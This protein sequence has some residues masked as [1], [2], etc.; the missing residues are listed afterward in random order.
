MIRKHKKNKLK[1]TGNMDEGRS[2]K[3][4]SDNL[5]K[6]LD[7]N[8][9]F[10][11]LSKMDFEESRN[12]LVLKENDYRIDI[13]NS[14]KTFLPDDKCK[15]IDNIVIALS[16]SPGQNIKPDINENTVEETKVEFINEDK[17]ETVDTNSN[18]NA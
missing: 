6:P 12:N 3:K 9:I 7:I 5:S 18:E 8:Q 15:I 1:D 11:I 17:P 10:S 14:L 4:G 16:I 13:L 2:N